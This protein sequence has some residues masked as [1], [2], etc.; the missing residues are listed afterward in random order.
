MPL[1][2]RYSFSQ[3]SHQLYIYWN[4]ENHRKLGVFSLLAA[5]LRHPCTYSITSP[6]RFYSSLGPG[7]SQTTMN[8]STSV[9]TTVSSDTEP[10]IIISFDSAKYIFNAG[11][12]TNRAFLQSRRNWK[13]TRGL[14]FT[15]VGTKRSSGLPGTRSGS[16][17]KTLILFYNI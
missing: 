4:S 15:D 1:D 12:N 14:F 3:S 8:W 17:N 16:Q 11:E 6:R 13:R 10:T 2:K 7:K 5:T 9:L